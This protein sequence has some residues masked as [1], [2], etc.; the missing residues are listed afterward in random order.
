MT[1]IHAIVN[2]MNEL[3]KDPKR[4]FV[5]YNV[6]PPGGSF[7]KSLADVPEN[8]IIE[9]P[10]AEN[11]VAGLAIGLS[12]AGHRPVL[13]F[14]RFDFV[15]GALD[16]LVNHLCKIYQLSDGQFKPSMIIRVIVGNRTKPLFTGPPHVQDFTGAMRLMLNFPVVELT[17]PSHISSYYQEAAERQSEHKSTMLVEYKDLYEMA[18]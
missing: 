17:D 16:A 8:Q 6:S 14:E 10:V 5:G 7:G 4:L 2:S 13:C 1:Y 15:L 9:T 11:L 12:I 3:A 18:F